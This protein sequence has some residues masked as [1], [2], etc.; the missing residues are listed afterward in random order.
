MEQE[1]FNMNDHRVLST[2]LSMKGKE[3]KEKDYVELD[4][5]FFEVLSKNLVDGIFPQEGL[6]KDEVI[7]SLNKMTQDI[8]I[9][10][11]GQR[12]IN[13]RI[14]DRVKGLIN[15]DVKVY[16]SSKFLKEFRTL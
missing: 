8:T 5:S 14:I 9:R 15:K 10:G 11:R 1:V 12:T 13:Y 3:L 4:N 16:L 6:A 2:L 7:A